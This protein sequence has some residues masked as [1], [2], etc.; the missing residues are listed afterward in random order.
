MAP[1][2]RPAA[3]H[4]YL[5]GTLS[6]GGLARRWHCRE[7]DI[8]RLLAARRLRFVQIDEH[9]RV[10]LPEVRRLE[11]RGCGPLWSSDP[12]DHVSTSVAAED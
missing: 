12:G 2:K 6:L 7:R 8:R 3:P 10:P 11:R 5:A 1:M 9:L 4:P